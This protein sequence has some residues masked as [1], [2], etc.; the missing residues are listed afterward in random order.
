MQIGSLRAHQGLRTLAAALGVEPVDEGEYFSDGLVHLGRNQLSQIELRQGRGQHPILTKRD[1]MLAGQL[2][3]ALGHMAPPTGR[4]ARR[5]VVVWVIPERGRHSAVGVF[6][7]LVLIGHARHR[8]LSQ[9]RYP[10]G[11]EHRLAQRLEG[12]RRAL[13]AHVGLKPRHHQPAILKSTQ[14]LGQALV[15][16]SLGLG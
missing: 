4:H 5:R 3:N 13:L 11:G 9:R 10:E 15:D 16:Y 8:S 6:D 7:C 1:T 12:V 14:E 2:D